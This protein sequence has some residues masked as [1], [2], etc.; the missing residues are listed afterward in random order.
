MNKDLKPY[1]QETQY[2]DFN[3]YMIK[4]IAKSFRERYRNKRKCAQ[5][6]FYWVKDSVRY[7]LG[8]WNVKASDTLFRNYGTCTNKANLLVA[9]YRAAGIPAGFGIMKVNGQRYLGPACIPMLGNQM[10]RKSVHTYVT[11][12]LDN[13]WIKI[14]PS[15]DKGLSESISHFNHTADEVHWDGIHNAE[16]NLSEDDIYSD[17]FPLANIDHIMAK[18]PRNAQGVKLKMF[19]LALEFYRIKGK[20]INEG[21]PLEPLLKRFFL[22]RYPHYYIIIHVRDLLYTYKKENGELHE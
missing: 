11:V 14:D 13:H 21:D 5:A 4:E 7:S 12:Y 2:C 10:S 6:L 15:D 17:E 20:E 19:N 22:L 8:Q 16:L 18:K 1:L 9:L 3:H